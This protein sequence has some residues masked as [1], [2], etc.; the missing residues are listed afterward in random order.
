[1]YQLNRMNKNSA[2]DSATRTASARAMRLSR[3]LGS[4]S[5]AWPLR[6]MNTPALASATSTQSS[7]TTM[8]SF[9]S[10]DYFT[11]RCL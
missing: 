7:A 2:T 6:N 10:G 11:R 8:M 3:A 9:M 4:A 1:M 5:S